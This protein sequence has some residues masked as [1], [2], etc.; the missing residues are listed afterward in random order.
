MDRI[1]GCGSRVPPLRTLRIGPNGPDRPDVMCST[2]SGKTIGVELTKSVWTWPDQGRERPGVFGEQLSQPD[3]QRKWPRPDHIGRVFL[4]DKSLRIRP[5][6]VPHFR[7]QLFE[8]LDWENAKPEPSWDPECSITAGSLG[9][10]P[11]L[12]HATRGAE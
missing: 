5:K 4:Y 2:A 9:L 1:S 11:E 7:T 8:F 12:E 6:D 10:G 3:W